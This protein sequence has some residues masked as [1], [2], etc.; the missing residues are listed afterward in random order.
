MGWAGAAAGW[1]A[2]GGRVGAFAALGGA[3]V[4]PPTID[5]Y[6]STFAGRLG[7]LLGSVQAPQLDGSDQTAAM[8]V[9][10]LRPI[11][12]RYVTLRVNSFGSWSMVDEVGVRVLP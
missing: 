2:L 8:T 4:V 7:Q 9:N 11:F 12:G 10:S 6:V 5:V 1:V 3:V